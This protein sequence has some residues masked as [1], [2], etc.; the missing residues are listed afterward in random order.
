MAETGLLGNLGN[1]VLLHQKKGLDLLSLRSS[2]LN[3]Q[4]GAFVFAYFY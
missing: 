1:G 2:L 4:A 3:E